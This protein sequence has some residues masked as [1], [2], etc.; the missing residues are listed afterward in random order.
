MDYFTYFMIRVRQLRRDRDDASQ[1]EPDALDGVVERLTSGEKWR[2][3]SGAELLRLM[4][5]ESPP[6]DRPTPPSEPKT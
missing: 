2:F 6:L 1:A 3:E 5:A 4:A